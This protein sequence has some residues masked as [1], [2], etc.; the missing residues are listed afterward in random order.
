MTSQSPRIYVYKITFEEVLYYYYG[1]HKEKRYNEEYWGTPVSNKWVWDFYTP[2]KQVLEI[3]DYTDDGW[4]EALEVEKRLIKPVYNTDKW[5]LNES[6]NG[7][8]SRE[9]LSKNGKLTQELGI[10]LFGLSEDEMRKARSKGGITCRETG[11]GIF[12]ISKEERSE[13]GK[14]SGKIN[15]TRHKE[16]RTGIFKIT[17]EER[18]AISK[19]VGVKMRDEKKGIFSMSPEMKTEMGKRLNAQRWKCLVTGYISTP[20]GLSQYQKKRGIDTS[21][22]E[23]IE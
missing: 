9:V 10:A 23:R 18:S 13:I 1:V 15:G 22:R 17:P 4:L 16:N 5:C 21:L 20:S 7:L 6:C 12:S 3:F 19:K 8:L 2:K 11:V 14:K